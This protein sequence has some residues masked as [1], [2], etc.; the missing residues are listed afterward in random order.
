VE[1]RDDSTPLSPK[2]CTDF[3][4]PVSE[5]TPKSK[6][7]LF[8]SRRGCSI[9]A[10]ATQGRKTLCKIARHFRE[11]NRVMKIRLLLLVGIA[12]LFFATNLR[13]QEDK[14]KDA[15]GCKDSETTPF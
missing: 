7:D 4:D 1:N 2:L 9:Q 14:P 13:A 12:T 11:D 5:G 3:F 6:K 15:E 10:R 8:A